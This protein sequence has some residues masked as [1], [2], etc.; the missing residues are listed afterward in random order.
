VLPLT[1]SLKHPPQE[2]YS[3]GGG[4][5]SVYG[6]EYKPGYDGYITWVND[7][8]PSWTVRGAGMGP[9]ERVELTGG[10]PVPVEPMYMVRCDRWLLVRGLTLLTDCQLGYLAQF[11]CY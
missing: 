6:F 11:R 3:G 2:C 5:Y 10:R 8:K 1:I 9:D 7:N 4:C